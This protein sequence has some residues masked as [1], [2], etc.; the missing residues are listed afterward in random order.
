MQKVSCFLVRKHVYGNSSG[1]MLAIFPIHVMHFNIGLCS[2]E[3]RFYLSWPPLLCLDC[4]S[5]TSMPLLFLWQLSYK[6]SD[7]TGEVLCRLWLPGSWLGA[8][9]AATGHSW[10]EYRHSYMSIWSRFACLRDHADIWMIMV[11]VVLAGCG[12][13]HLHSQLC[14]LLCMFLC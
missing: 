3:G 14:H 4:L 8:N 9:Q 6:A 1:S 13:V 12:E 5:L 2:Q 11:K 7:N 10:C